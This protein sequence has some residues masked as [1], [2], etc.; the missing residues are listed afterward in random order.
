MEGWKAAGLPGTAPRQLLPTKWL[1]TGAYQVVSNWTLSLFTY[2]RYYSTGQ[3]KDLIDV[4]EVIQE[5]IPN[6]SVTVEDKQNPGEVIWKS[7]SISLGASF[8]F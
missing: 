5:F 1:V 7:F 4:T 2:Y 6:P 8:S 3:Q